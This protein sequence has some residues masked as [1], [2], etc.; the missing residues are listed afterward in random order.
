[1]KPFGELALVNYC[2]PD[3]VPLRNIMRLPKDEAF[4][5]ARSL[6]EAHPDTTAFYRFADFENYYT[7]RIR[8][9]AYLRARFIEAGGRPEVSHP[10]S[11]VLEGSDY[12]R[13]WFAGGIETRLLLRDIDAVHVSFTIGDSGAEFQRNG[14]AEL[15]TV[16]MLRARLQEQ[17][18]LKAL[19]DAAGKHYVEAQ[20]WSDRYIFGV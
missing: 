11:F 2:H 12:L 6:A 16:D 7:L 13:Q 1:M 9:D 3:C 14:C 17:G 19:L 20:L 4:L 10:L 15:L 18:N 5:L 8:Q